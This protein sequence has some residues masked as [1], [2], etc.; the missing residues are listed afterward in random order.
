MTMTDP[1]S[2]AVSPLSDSGVERRHYHT[3]GI[4]VRGYHRA[5]GLWDIEGHM[6]DTK[7][8][9]FVNSHRG[10]ITPGDPVHD[11]WLRI[12]ID[13]D[14]T[15]HGAEAKT[16]AGPYTLCGDIA[17]A[18]EQLIGLRI[19]PGFHRA[20]KQRLG[21]VQG[22][23]HITEML[24]P[25]ATVCYQTAYASRD[26]AFAD[27]GKEVPESRADANKRPGHIGACHAMRPDGPVVKEVWPRFYEGE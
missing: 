24:Y 14:M 1:M 20:V 8:Y 11:M 7:T 3:R 10:E 15:I 26:R 18:Y 25:M 27:F 4:E 12:T 2:D 19:G 9:P 6:R 22:C 5:D 23:T 13:D 16:A 17:P 21:G